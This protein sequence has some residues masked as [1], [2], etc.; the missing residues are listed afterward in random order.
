MATKLGHLAVIV[1]ARTSAFVKGMMRAKRFVSGVGDSIVAVGKR[2]AMFGGLLG[3]AVVA[4]IAAITKRSLDAIDASSKMAAAL[5]LS[6]EQ[7][8]G[9][10]HAAKL[11]GA[12]NQE[13]T[14]ALPPMQKAI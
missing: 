13:V 7:L 8:A 11:G 5:G 3:G 14:T 2:A 1:T 12:S 9:Y 6:T 10:E 4:G